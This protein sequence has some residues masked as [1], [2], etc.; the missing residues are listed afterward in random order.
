VTIWRKESKSQRGRTGRVG[1]NEHRTIKGGEHP[2]EGMGKRSVVISGDRKTVRKRRGN[3]RGPHS[4]NPPAEKNEIN[5][6]KNRF[7]TAPKGRQDEVRERSRGETS[8]AMRKSFTRNR[9][10]PGD[11]VSLL[12]KGLACAG[13]QAS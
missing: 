8:R 10:K 5:A 6:K 13:L 12:L 4:G 11:R 2:R 7:Q 1:D 9:W 3:Q